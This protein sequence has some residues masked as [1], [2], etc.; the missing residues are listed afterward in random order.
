LTKDL[1]VLE[2]HCELTE[3]ERQ[4]DHCDQQMKP[5]GKKVKRE[6]VCFVPAKLYKKV[7]VCH[8][9]ECNCHDPLYEA[10]PIK[11]SSTPKGPIQNSL[12][13]ASVL[14]FLMHQKYVLSLPLYRQEAEW[15]R[16][17]LKVSRRT[18]ANWVIT[19][20]QDW[21][22]HIYKKLHRHLVLSE[23][24][25]ADETPYQILNRT[26]GKAATS[27]A[28]I[29][30][31]RTTH[32]SERPIV[33]YH[34]DLTRKQTV[35]Q[36]VLEG[37]KGYIQ[38]DGYS[39]YKN[40]D[41]CED[42]GCWAHVRRKFYEVPK[43]GQASIG[44][45]YCDEMFKIE[46]DLKDLPPA[47]RH[48]KRQKK[49]KPLIQKFY[50][51]IGGLRPMKGKLGEAITYALNQK[52]SLM[53]VLSDGRLQ[54]SNNLAEQKMRNIAIGRKNYLFSA[55]EAGARANAIVYTLVETAKE[56]GIDPFN[57]LEY[58]FEK[59]PNINFSRNPKLLEDFLPWTDHIK[60][61]CATCNNINASEVLSFS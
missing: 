11:S 40:I 55:S 28:R 25:H 9:Y 38:S 31:F 59:L 13:S 53:R 4:C 8:S 32:Q 5:M 50:E 22:Y 1:P 41:N 14:A 42:V 20:A 49:L 6:E 27:D 24:I 61:N 60:L 2:I 35:V 12:A 29:W 47:Q 56:N 19:S 43:G 52:D 26:D 57:Y 7:Y 17:G 33:M 58:L 23:V 21:L 34:A 48:K 10:K 18:L 54:L 51:W 3:Q 37:F 30:V 36:G 46:R 39:A 16:Y 44:V 45:A 15:Q